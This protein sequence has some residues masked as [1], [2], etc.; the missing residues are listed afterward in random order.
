M[1]FTLELQGAVNSFVID[2][3]FNRVHATLDLGMSVGWSVG[4]SVGR[5]VVPSVGQSTS[6]LFVGPS[7]CP[8]NL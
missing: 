4:K 1:N 8:L 2:A 5:L 3:F 7:V 6:W